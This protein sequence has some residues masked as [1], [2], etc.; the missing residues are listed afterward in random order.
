MNK[1]IYQELQGYYPALL[2]DQP[3]L[4]I[5]EETKVNQLNDPPKPQNP[6]LPAELDVIPETSAENQLVLSEEES[7]E[8]N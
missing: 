1:K 7:L 5:P 4:A 3:G 6:M 8:I 2:L